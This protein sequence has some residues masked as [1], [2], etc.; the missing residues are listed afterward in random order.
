V[1]V[2]KRILV[3]QIVLIALLSCHQNK[4]LNWPEKA[5]A[6]LFIPQKIEN[7][8]YY[9]LNGTYQTTYKTSACW[10]GEQYIDTM[11]AHMVKHGWKRLDEDFLNPGLKPN[12]ARQG[13]I[14]D[15]WGFF[16][17][18]GKDVHQW[19]EDW[20]DA[21]KNLVRY[22]LWYR[23][24][25]KGNVSITPQ[26]CDMEVAVIFTPKEIRDRVVTEAEAWRK[27]EAAKKATPK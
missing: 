7:Q 8:K 2:L 12:W 16:E 3:L 17:E 24:V 6:S 11:V 5:E 10:P 14:F 20:E 27:D 15:R 1:N 19:M 9:E 25:R 18:K 21:D 26:T 22:G 23:T 13:D 4:P